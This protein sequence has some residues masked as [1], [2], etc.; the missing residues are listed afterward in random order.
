MAS[1]GAIAGKTGK[2]PLDDVM[3]AMDVVDTLRHDDNLVA[4]ELGAS[5]REAALIERL[6]KI[7]RDQGIEVPDHIL[8]EGVKA[9][10]ESRFTY[11]PPPDN[12]STRLAKLYV[13]R[14]RWGRPALIG[15][16]LLAVVLGGYFLA[17]R[18]YQASV[19]AAAQ[20]ELAQELPARMDEIYQ[21]I[22]NETKVQSALEVAQPWVDRGKA[23]AARGDRD[24]A[25]AAIEQLETIHATL[26][27][28]Y[29]IRIVNRP[30]E[31]TGIWRFP[32]NNSAATNY[33]LV[34]EAVGPDDELV[35]LP[36]TNEETGQTEEVSTWAIRVPDVTYESVRADRQDDG[37]IQRNILGIKQYGFLDTDFAMP[38]LDGA[39]TQW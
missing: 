29:S 10:A 4:R 34:V 25:L 33:Y 7:Y 8:K 22:F 2:A 18:P 20:L 11:A 28:D 14:A 16:A 1:G 12:L 26:L 30:G 21:Q 35:T 5:S 31:S 17:Y 3:L 27:A 19:E 13:G 6:R 37:I 9:L 36:I 32:E 23:A 38:V 24:D 39:I 15:V